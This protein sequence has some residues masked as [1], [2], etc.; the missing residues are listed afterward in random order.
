[1]SVVATPSEV[2][3]AKRF[4]I[5]AA[6]IANA[7]VVL[8][9]I[10][11]LPWPEPERVS[12]LA[13]LAHDAQAD[14]GVV[15]SRL[16]LSAAP[17]RAFDE[18]IPLYGIAGKR[19]LGLV[20]ALAKVDVKT[21]SPDAERIRDAWVQVSAL[22]AEN[23][24]LREELDRL[25]TRLGQEPSAASTQLLGVGALASSV[26]SQVAAAD[27]ALRSR[28]RGLQ[29][30]YVEL[31]VH[32]RAAAVGN[33]LALDVGS[34]LKESAVGFRFARP[35]AA[36]ATGTAMTVPNVCGYTAGFARRKLQ[37]LG[38]S[39]TVT[40][41]AGGGDTVSEQSPSP[42]AVLTAGSAVR[43]IIR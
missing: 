19:T 9:T 26:G 25:N 42:G 39:A 27:D 14:V 15:L 13:R 38:Y 28:A 31:T 35:D 22:R 11:A 32:G 34:S 10:A 43:L 37:A 29:L 6:S 18:L 17:L 16:T 8:N 40:R 30:G 3:L 12:L 1:V 4:G 2:A 36:S 20:K 24:A 41:V 33:D 5:D 21:L 7:R 23:L